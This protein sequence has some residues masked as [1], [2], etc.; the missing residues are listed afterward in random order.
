VHS[1]TRNY[2]GFNVLDNNVYG[3]RREY[4]KGSN[5]FLSVLNYEAGVIENQLDLDGVDD[6]Y[7]I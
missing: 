3:V 1:K 7:L 4:E 6:N 2:D 5:K